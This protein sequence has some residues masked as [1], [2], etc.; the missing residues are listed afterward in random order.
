M[1]QRL[2][3]RTQRPQDV[4]NFRKRQIKNFCCLLMLS[5]GTPMFRM[6]DEFMQTQGGNN[7]PYNQDN[8]TSWLDW[9]RLKQN[10]EVFG[11]FKRMIAFRKA[12][13]SWTRRHSGV[14]TFAG[15]ASTGTR[16]CPGILFAGLLPARR[17]RRRPGHLRPDQRLL[18][19]AEFG[20]HEG[21]PGDWRRWCRSRCP[22]PTRS[23]PKTKPPSSA[24]AVTASQAAPWWCW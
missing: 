24:P 2:G 16:T 10:Q 4:M 15:T 22:A 13:P 6:G 9:R 12:H 18:G 14:T 17:V 23:C 3:R 19:R 5:A 21:L 11:F 1:Q 20:I 8:E 7:N